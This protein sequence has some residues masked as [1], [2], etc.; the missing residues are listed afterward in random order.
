VIYHTRREH[1]NHYTTR[2]IDLVF[3][4]WSCGVMVSVLPSCVID[5]VFKTW[6]CDVMVNVL[7]SCVID[8]VFKT[9]SCGVMVSNDQV[10]NT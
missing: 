2:V 4:T 7:P 5:H 9:W 8:H 1:T 10:L 3:K 6:S